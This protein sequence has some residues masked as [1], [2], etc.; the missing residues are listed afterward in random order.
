MAIEKTFRELVIQIQRLQEALDALGTTVEEDRPRRN[1]VVVASNLGDVLLAVQ[2]L[3]EESRA[4]A[5]EACRAVG[6]PLDTD[7]ARRTLT[8]CQEGFHRFA[9]QFSLDLVS[10]DRIADLMSVAAERG[11]EWAH[12][13][14]VV[15]EGL[16]QCQALVE[17]CRD[18]LFLCWQEL[19]ERAGTTSVS[20]RNTTIGQQIAAP[21]LAGHELLYEAMT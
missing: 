4:A 1:D 11:R 12:W 14:K 18:A 9:S 20:V 8:A 13:V 15:K 17:R 21:E 6:H 5:D 7:Q 19:V 10:Y 16:E 3:L 2:G